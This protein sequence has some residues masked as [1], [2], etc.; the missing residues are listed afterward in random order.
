MRAFIV[1][2]SLAFAAVLTIAAGQPTPAAPVFTAA[3]ADAGQT[4]Y[5][6][7][8]ASCHLPD[9]VGQNEAP[10]L[11]GANFMTTWRA[12]TARDL[13]DYMQ[14]TMP[15]GRPSL[16][17]G[18]YVNNAAF[19]LRSNGAAAGDEPLRRS[20]AVAIGSIATGQLAAARPVGG[21]GAPPAR[22]AGPPPSRGHSVTGEVRNYV[23]VTDAML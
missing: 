3:Q 9:L 5:H 4:S 13:I 16:A 17:E 7:N 19:V 14:A 12:R 2:V 23:P 20:T 18:D 15:P 6:A 10:P 8:C 11:A 22:P 1:A 21:E